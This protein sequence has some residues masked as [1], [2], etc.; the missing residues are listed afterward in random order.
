[1]KNVLI[2][3][4][5]KGIGRS[6]A[7]K[8][9]E[10]DYFVIGTTKESSDSFV[11]DNI[12]TFMLDLSKE[13]SISNCTNEIKKLLNEKNI[14]IDILIN[15][16]GILV[17]NDNTSVDVKKLRETLEVNLFGTISFTEN[18]LPYIK[19][20]GHIVNISSSAGSLS[21]ALDLR[22]THYPYHY[23]AYKISKCA[24]NMYTRTLALRMENEKTGIIVSSI[25]PGWVKTDMGGD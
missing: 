15:N 7:L 13:D 22:K 16:A 12:K 21:G 18:I 19:E 3:G 24:I 4:I 25:H 8:F 10:Q 6:L 9:R 14:K 5:G 17:D 23:P 2:T 1:M 11:N 20:G